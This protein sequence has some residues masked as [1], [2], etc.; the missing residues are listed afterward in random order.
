M[1]HFSR[2]P[3]SIRF[4]CKPEDHGVIAEPVPA[5]TV[6]PDWFRKLP[7]STSSMRRPPTTA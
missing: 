7:P 6:L 5:K 2:T 3:A 4:L 1:F